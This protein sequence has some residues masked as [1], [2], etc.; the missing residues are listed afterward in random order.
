LA[1][2]DQAHRPDPSVSGVWEELKA[3]FM[4]HTKVECESTVVLMIED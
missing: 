4:A 3:A 2:I 1:G